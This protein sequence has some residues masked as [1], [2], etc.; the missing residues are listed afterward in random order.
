MR[1]STFDIP[2]I[3]G[4]A[5]D[6]EKYIALPRGGLDKAI[7]LMKSLGIEVKVRDERFKGGTIE[8]SFLGELRSE[9]TLTVTEMLK[10]DTG[11]LCA[12]TAFG[13][14][15]SA[16]AMIA[17][18]KVSTLILVHRTQLM[19]QWAS[20]LSSFLGIDEKQIGKLGGGKRKQ[21]GFIDIALMQSLNRKGEIDER[22]AEYGQIIVDECHHLSAF[23]FE[24]I[25]KSA[26]A[27]YVLGLTAT[28]I[29]RDGHYPIIFMQCGNTLSS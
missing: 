4:C 12:P 23:S 1:L 15:V 2:R 26:K 19:D 27:K 16:A 25:L 17:E 28:P 14:T 13:K 29:R 11:V 6:F 7:S 24:Q 5:E 22:I 18:R 20:R 21:G 10:H 8:V 9:Q 3:I